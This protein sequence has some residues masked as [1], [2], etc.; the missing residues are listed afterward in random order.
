M[1]QVI[2]QNPSRVTKDNF[3]TTNTKLLLS[4]SLYQR[5]GSL[6]Q[7]KTISEDYANKTLP[8]EY[9]T[10]LDKM[11]K[12]QSGTGDTAS[13]ELDEYIGSLGVDTQYHYEKDTIDIPLWFKP[14]TVS[15]VRNVA[16][17]ENN[18][19]NGSDN[20]IHTSGA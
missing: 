18:I 13:I 8:A 17:G 14:T 7:S 3:S 20:I 16:N 6:I 4:R 10:F 1:K 12:V 9:I 19:I 15:P 2:L 11:D 5:L